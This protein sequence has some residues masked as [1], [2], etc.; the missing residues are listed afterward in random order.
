MSVEVH[1]KYLL[2]SMVIDMKLHRI[3]QSLLPGPALPRA[4]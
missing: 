1:T 4:G 2:M 3:G